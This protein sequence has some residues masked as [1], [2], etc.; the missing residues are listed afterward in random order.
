MT[1]QQERIG[2]LFAALCAL[3]GSLVPAMAKLTTDR[4][5]P[6]FVAMVTTLF[7]AGFSVLVLGIRGELTVP[8]LQVVR[9]LFH[10][11]SGLLSGRSIE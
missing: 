10:I 9:A 8:A 7:G 3:N 5:A 6:L 1:R 2:L 4:G 11:R